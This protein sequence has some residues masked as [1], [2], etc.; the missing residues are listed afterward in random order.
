MWYS[1][2]KSYSNRFGKSFADTESHQCKGMFQLILLFL[3]G[4]KPA[5]PRPYFCFY[6]DCESLCIPNINQ[7]LSPFCILPFLPHPTLYSLHGLYNETQLMLFAYSC[8]DIFNI[9]F[10]LC[11]IQ[12][13]PLSLESKAHFFLTG[14]SGSLI[15]AQNTLWSKRELP[16]SIVFLI[17]DAKKNRPLPNKRI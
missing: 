4:P 7:C 5:A 8:W 14:P 6:L 11:S 16:P 3:T 13:R 9:R 1:V 15:H 17:Q 12:L 10:F 2:R